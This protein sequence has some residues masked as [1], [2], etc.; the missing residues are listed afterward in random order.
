[1][2]KFSVIGGDIDLVQSTN[3]SVV[4]RYPN[5][6]ERPFPDRLQDLQ[7]RC[8]SDLLSSIQ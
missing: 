1:M 6:I 5:S 7:I 3:L 4:Q 2:V 8:I